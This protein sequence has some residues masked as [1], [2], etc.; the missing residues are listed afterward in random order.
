MV[1]KRLNGLGREKS[2]T[3]SDGKLGCCQLPECLDQLLLFEAG[4]FNK[5]TRS[6]SGTSARNRLFAAATARLQV[7]FGS[8]VLGNDIVLFDLLL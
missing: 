3:E 5:V 4:S 6:P 1:F 7:F 8:N 2:F